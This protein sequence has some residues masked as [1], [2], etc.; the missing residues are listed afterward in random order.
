[1]NSFKRQKKKKKNAESIGTLIHVSCKQTAPLIDT[2]NLC[3]ETEFVFVLLKTE[4]YKSTRSVVCDFHFPR[5]F[6]FFNPSSL[7]C[8]DIIEISIKYHKLYTSNNGGCFEAFTVLHFA[9]W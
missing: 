6:C 8:S 2:E 4:L 1:M 5:I 7:A 3:L 9:L